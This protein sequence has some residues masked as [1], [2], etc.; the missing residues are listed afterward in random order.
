MGSSRVASSHPRF[1][2]QLGCCWWPRQTEASEL[3]LRLT[4]PPVAAHEWLGGVINIASLRPVTRTPAGIR[5]RP[6]RWKR[7]D[8]LS[9]QSGTAHASSCS[10]MCGIHCKELRDEALKSPQSETLSVK[11]EVTAISQAADKTQEEAA[12]DSGSGVRTIKACFGWQSSTVSTAI[13]G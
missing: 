9:S 5:S 12:R 11:Q 3:R 10:Q 2:L 8:G 6:A 4:E 13:V 7:C 1:L